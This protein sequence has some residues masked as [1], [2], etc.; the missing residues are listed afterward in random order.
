MP[1][2]FEN[3]FQG[4][5]Q[6]RYFPLL[7]AAAIFF[8][9]LAIT[10]VLWNGAQ[11]VAKR[12]LQTE[13]DFRVQEMTDVIV[14]RMAAYEQVLLG[15]RGFFTS[16]ERVTRAEFSS[17]VSS[18]QLEELFP[19]IQGVAL[20]ELIPKAKLNRHIALMRKQG[21]P[22]YTVNPYGDREVYT[23]ITVIEPFN[24]MNRRAFGFDMFSEPTRRDAMERARDTGNAAL[25]GKVTLVQEGDE[26]AQP[27]FLMYVPVYKNGASVNSV[28]LR[29]ANIISWVYAPFR[30][31]DFMEGLGGTR[32][33]DVQLSIYDGE[34]FSPEACIYGCGRLG[35]NSSLFK[36]IANVDIAGHAWTMD[37]VSTP[38]FQKRMQSE[39]PQFIA[40]SGTG[41]SML[42]ALLVWLL[43]TRRNRAYALAHEMTR[44]LKESEFRW[45]Y[46][47]EGA[48][49]GVWDWNRK[50]NTA[51]VS[52]RWKQMLGYEDHDIEDELEVWGK[53][54][55]PEEVR[56]VEEKWN[57]F[58]EGKDQVLSTEFRMRCKDGSWKWIHS[59]G[60]AVNRDEKGR[61]MRAIGTHAD[62]TAR[63]DAERLELERT[64]A[65]N[66]ARDSLRH[67]QK[68]EAVGKLT[69]GVAHD[70]NNVLQIISGNIQLL[71][72]LLSGNK[73]VEKRLQNMLGAVDRGS[74]LSS[75][76][77]AFARRQPLQPAVVNLYAVI[78]NMDDLLHRA[79]GASIQLQVKACEG[80]WNTFVDPS[81]LENVI[82]NLVINA[83]DAM[84]EGGTLLIKLENTELKNKFAN[85]PQ[86][87]AAGD[88][89][90][91]CICDTGTGMSPEVLEQVFEPFFT[92]KPAGEGTGLGLSMAYGF[93][94][95]SGGHIQIE[96]E[97]GKGTLI[98]IYL[99]RSLQEA[100]PRPALKTEPAA[101]G[102]ETILVVEDDLDVQTTV[103]GMLKI[104][105]YHVLAA[106][107]GDRA[108]EIIKS[109][110]G[111]DLLFS[112]VVMP[113]ALSAPE[114]AKQARQI[115]P[116]I[117][118]LFTSGYTRN[119]LVSG[120]RL[121]EGVQLLSKPYTHTQLA[122]RI[123]QVLSQQDRQN[124][125]KKTAMS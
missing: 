38:E 19:G 104:L 120:G 36:T 101:G 37:F 1:D 51:R 80:L 17:Y 121:E 32:S 66:E 108:L 9:S 115:Q 78:Q 100:M 70:F 90:L 87:V 95:Q 98:R 46:A 117:A 57:C 8:M 5:K 102:R 28:E 30:M 14:H 40:V 15:T 39:R 68:L 47:L 69:G 11:S 107:N 71:Q 63:K 42:L 65:L 111:I 122:Q 31:H 23:A 41:L 124:L 29:R 25:S 77:L 2:S 92:T 118:V 112:D 119:A 53:L 109:N 64:R 58:V 79:L 27:G 73:E 83:R 24:E 62:I 67:A 18:L 105:G 89:V 43:A 13:F 61:V 20:S 86:E 52:K 113:G 114:L 33:P 22:E 26:Q 125:G 12:N 88:Y 55:H 97:V 99:P 35:F 72:F 106:E 91:L 4:S 34:S 21:F 49:D 123:R 94:K 96:S 82:L 44:Q 54:V 59:R 48:G 10:Y 7:L 103:I 110:P 116:H 3:S 45:K 56:H 74:K 75:Q 50:Q 76:L 93:V 6:N 84:P 16:S 85:L 81:Q 60:A